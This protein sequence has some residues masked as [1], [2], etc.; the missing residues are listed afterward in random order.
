VTSTGAVPD[1][2][3]AADTL[4]R[5]ADLIDRLIAD[6]RVEQLP[7]RWAVNGDQ[8]DQVNCVDG[9]DSIAETWTW[10]E[11]NHVATF[12]PHTV[13]ALAPLLR[14]AA[15]YALWAVE[16]GERHRTTFELEDWEAD[17]LAFAR[18]VLRE[19][20]TDGG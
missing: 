13:V 1:L 15:K 16:A 11:A 17:L 9:P 7:D 12:D 4:N 2:T 20:E 18:R 5:A 8:G 14:R 10:R 19:E 6:Y 3:A